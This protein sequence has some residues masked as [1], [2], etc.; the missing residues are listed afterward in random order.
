MKRYSKKDVK[1]I[2]R[3]IKYGENKIIVQNLNVSPGAVSQ[4][5]S[6]VYYN[7]SILDEA[8][9]IIEEREAK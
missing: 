8:N 1:L 6:G 5:L 9:R 3:K 2:H 4:V 7:Q